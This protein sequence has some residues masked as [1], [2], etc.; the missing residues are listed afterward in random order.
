MSFKSWCKEFFPKAPSSAMT[1]SAASHHAMRKWIGVRAYNVERHCLVREG[2]MISDGS[3]TAFLYLASESCALCCIN[4]ACGTCTLYK[5]QGFACG[6]TMS[7]YEQ[8]TKRNPDVE[9][10][11][12]ALTKAYR[13][14]L[15]EKRKVEKCRTQ[16][17]SP[18]KRSKLGSTNAQVSAQQCSGA[19]SNP[20]T[21]TQV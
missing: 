8:A 19:E 12:K 4:L 2:F 3:G 7:P 20:I 6:R 18:A 9:P 15:R 21:K 17:K 1:K 10:L 11:I 5:V 13:N 14:D 16:K